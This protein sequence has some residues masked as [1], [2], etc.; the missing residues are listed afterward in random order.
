[1]KLL[2]IIKEQ[3][4]ISGFSAGVKVDYILRK[5]ARAV[6]FDKDNK[7]ALL[8]VSKKNYHKLPGGGIKDN[9]NIKEGLERECEEEIGCDIEIKREIGLIKEYRDK[10]NIFQESYC[11]LAKIR[12]KKGKPNFTKKELNHGFH[13]NWVKLDNAINLIKN[14]KPINYEGKFIVIRDLAFLKEVKKLIE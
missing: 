4:V 1:M 7:I 11:Y 10:I 8:N 9:E 13:L 14:D 6:V 12:G 3:D 5:A 2:K